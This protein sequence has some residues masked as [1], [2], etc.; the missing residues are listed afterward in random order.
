LPVPELNINAADTAASVNLN[1]LNAGTQ[2]YYELSA[3]NSCGTSPIE[4][5][6]FSTSAA[7]TDAYVG[8]VYYLE[9]PSNPHEL[10]QDGTV[11]PNVEVNVTA[12]C[13]M[14]GN[15][16]KLGSPGKVL[17][18]YNEYPG[19][20]VGMI[21][22]SEGYYDFDFPLY[23]AAAAGNLGDIQFF[24]LSAGGNCLTQDTYE[25][26]S[27]NYANANLEV[28]AGGF[29]GLWTDLEYVPSTMNSQTD[30]RSFV[31]DANPLGYSAAAL[32]LV[33]T[34][35]ANCAS[36]LT[37]TSTQTVI[38]S[39]GGNGNS[40][41]YTATETFG[42]QYP[43]WG[44][45][46]GVSLGW[47]VGGVVNDSSLTP[48]SDWPDGN[49]PTVAAVPYT[50]TDWLSDTTWNLGNPGPGY[51]ALE[52]PPSYTESNPYLFTVSQTTT[53][54]STSGTEI[55]VEVGV[56]VGFVSAGIGVELTYTTTDVYTTQPSL[57]CEL[58]DPSTTQTAVFYYTFDGGTT[59]LAD[60][61][62]VWLP[63]YCAVGEQDC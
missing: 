10:L 23:A 26:P 62:H 52:I 16:G 33:H 19:E 13:Q 55:D 4:S 20:N 18:Y 47:A 42:G 50:T 28:T 9:S 36:A 59:N 53:Y 7:P 54:S 5:G 24:T 56:N 60:V 2:Y 48:V 3:T 37:T 12:V 45:D 11:A 63:G 31:L 58:Y 34:S 49:E 44:V 35:A 8:W 25:G 29:A 6:I 30:Y 41:T 40:Q 21:T 14:Y 27:S 43:G 57:S 51:L 38:A 22:N 17:F 39:A 32:A 61:I 15:Y 46:S 1:A